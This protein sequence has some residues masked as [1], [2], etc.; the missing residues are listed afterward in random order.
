M[1]LQRTVWKKHRLRIQ[2][3]T[4]GENWEGYHSHIGWMVAQMVKN[5]PAM[6]ET[7]VRS[8]GQED[9]LEKGMA[10]H[11]IFLPGKPHGKRI[12]VG[13]SPWGH[14]EW[15]RNE[16]LSLAHSPQPWVRTKWEEEL[17]KLTTR[18]WCG[19][20][21]KTEH[22]VQAQTDLPSEKLLGAAWNSSEIS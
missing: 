8:L 13:Y 11:S 3:S 16:R 21:C 10:T 15:D 1:K 4:E 2:E 19:S 9:P 18:G 20:F 6:Q 14:K 7:L 17:Q 5:L 22:K 12:L